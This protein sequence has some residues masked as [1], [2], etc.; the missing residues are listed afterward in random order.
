MDRDKLMFEAGAISARTARRSVRGW[1]SVAA[2]LAVALGCESLIL[3]VRPGRQPLERMVVLREP[4]PK[5]LSPEQAG[6][7]S[8]SFTTPEAIAA[9]PPRIVS[10]LPRS[11]RESVEQSSWTGA[12][13]PQRLAELVLRFG[14]DAVPEQSPL[15]SRDTGKPD[16]PPSG[17]EPAGVLRRI[18][19]EKLSNPGDPS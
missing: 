13:D 15:V 10:S 6:Q 14:L 16:S 8:A 17:F 5:G 1:A 2:A 12:S 19:L 3:A 7:S 18:E 4:R 11:L 9:L